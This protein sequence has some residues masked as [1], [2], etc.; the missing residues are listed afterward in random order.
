MDETS[1]L[2]QAHTHPILKNK[3][4]EEEEEEEKGLVSSLSSFMASKQYR[5]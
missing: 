4:E 3:K 2:V 1:Y 5:S